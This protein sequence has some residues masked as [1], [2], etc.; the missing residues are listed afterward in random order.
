M[1]WGQIDRGGRRGLQGERDAGNQDH[2]L[3]LARRLPRPRAADRR[4][5]Q[6]QGVRDRCR[7]SDLDGLGNYRVWV[8]FWCGLCLYDCVDRLDG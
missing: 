2:L 3:G 4:D 6:G 5:G 1:I 7:P 8:Q